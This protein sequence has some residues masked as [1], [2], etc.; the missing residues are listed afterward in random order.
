VDKACYDSTC[1]DV[2]SDT[3]CGGS[4]CCASNAVCRGVDH[5][6]ECSCPPGTEGDPRF[7]CQPC[8]GASCNRGVSGGGSRG[9]GVS[10]GSG[11]LCSPNPCGTQAICTPGHDNT[12]KQRPVCT[13]P[14]GYQGNALVN[15]RRGECLNDNE[16]SSH[17]AC[18]D[19][20]CRDPCIG[21]CG[22]NSQCQ[23][24]NHGPV[25]AC[26]AGFEGDPLNHCFRSGSGG[27]AAGTRGNF[28]G[29]RTHGCK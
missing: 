14:K 15:C 19:F 1:I 13:C 17:Q 28:G 24:R 4:P 16:C 20:K 7:G 29:C 22:S 3:F 11:S 6:A 5:L 23:V 21:V 8:R 18:F 9:T 10:S 27:A 2:C 25:C 26:M 12:G